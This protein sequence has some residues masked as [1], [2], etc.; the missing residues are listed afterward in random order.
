MRLCLK[1]VYL[2]KRN[3]IK[4]VNNENTKNNTTTDGDVGDVN[5]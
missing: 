5:L 4:I 2:H 1:V 3:R